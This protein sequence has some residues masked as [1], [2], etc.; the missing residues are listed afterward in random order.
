MALAVLDLRVELQ[1]LLDRFTFSALWF[2]LSSHPLA[3][4]VLALFPWLI[5]H[6]RYR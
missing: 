5:K 6:D 1:L 3:V 2:G 4:A